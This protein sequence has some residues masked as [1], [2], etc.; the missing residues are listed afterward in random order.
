M[1]DLGNSTIGSHVPADA[2]RG[3]PAR[4]VR[5]VLGEPARYVQG[6]YEQ[7]P[8]ATHY[9]SAKT[10]R[11]LARLLVAEARIVEGRA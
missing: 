5:L 3:Y 4:T 1:I 2:R 11:R 8:Q 9:M 10:A 7:G 6:R